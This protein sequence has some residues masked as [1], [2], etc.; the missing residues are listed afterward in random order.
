MA[1]RRPA[2]MATLSK[3]VG[4]LLEGGGDPDEPIRAGHVTVDGGVVTNPAS[5]VR[6]GSAVQLREGR[7]LRGVRKL[8]AALEQWPDIDLEGAV[9]LDAGASAG[10]FTR[11]LLDAGA[12]RVY[13]VEAGFGQ[14]IGSL[15][16]DQRVVNL[17]RTN[18]GDLDA[19]TVPDALTAITLDLGYLALATAVPQLGARL[20]IAPGA[21]LMA[22]VKPMF[23]LGLGEP[24]DDRATLDEALR[25][26]RE[27]IEAGGWSVVDA[28][29]SPVKGSKG[30]RELFVRARRVAKR[31]SAP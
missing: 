26:A 6:A 18:I 12:A 23:E 29:D 15:R 9:A 2:K 14:L 28:I 17:E 19:A 24:P 13:A 22:L 21:E 31:A 25:H 27:G 3:R 10:G 20:D 30:A 7:V 8:G 11:A 5:M 1:R 4:E 16:Q